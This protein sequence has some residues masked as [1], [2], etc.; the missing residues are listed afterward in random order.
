M[1]NFT[2]TA[3]K[4]HVFA[5]GGIIVNDYSSIILK[6]SFYFN[7]WTYIGDMRDSVTG[8][9]HACRDEIIYLVGG[10]SS[11]G[12]SIKF[13]SSMFHKL[14]TKT[15][16]LENLED[17]PVVLPEVQIFF[18]YRLCDRLEN[19]LIAVPGKNIDI[20]PIC[21]FNFV[22]NEWVTI[23]TNRLGRPFFPGYGHSVINSCNNGELYYIFS[24]DPN[25][26]DILH[27][28]CCLCFTVTL[29]EDFDELDT[30]F[31]KKTILPDIPKDWYHVKGVNAYSIL[32]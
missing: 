19:M 30:D 13:Y 3:V 21:I 18:N 20:F 17:M 32:L 31:V 26:Y 16:R 4:S 8:I 9:A 10:H 27:S 25:K 2:L 29:D 7:S 24:N 15:S 1:K 28:S 12:N 22:T 6:Y 23:E 5:V 14:N 11:D